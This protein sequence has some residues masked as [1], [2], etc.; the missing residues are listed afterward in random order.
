MNK[1]E[2]RSKIREI[3]DLDEQ[4]LSNTLL[5]MYIKDGFDRIIALERRWPFYQ[6]TFTL[7]TVPAQRAYAV[8]TVGDG[9]LREI[10]SLVDTS[11][12]GNRLEFIAYDDA[13]AVWVGSYDQVSRPLYFTFWEDQIHLWPKPDAVYPLVVRGYRKPTD[14]SASDS[15]EVD[16]DERLHQC[17]VYYGVAQVYQLQEDIEL[18]SYYRKTFDEAVRL[19]A[20]DIMR[21]S[22]QRPLAFSDGVPHPS[23]RWWLQS[24]G[25]TLGQ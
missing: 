14:W 24:L 5:D 9:N 12:V 13:E 18:A 3:V 7:N 23:R 25:R 21:P 2:I 6:K 16:A 1:S 20:A 15:T 17:L 4:D 8:N 11:T 19:S 10:I 22:S